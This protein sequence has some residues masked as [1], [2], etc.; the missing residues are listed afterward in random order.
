[1]GLEQ[2]WGKS[3]YNELQGSHWVGNSRNCGLGT[4][5]T[6]MVGVGGKFAT[7]DRVGNKICGYGWG[8]RENL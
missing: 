5:Y 8:L 7:N 4:K 6:G 3:K 2:G 1:M